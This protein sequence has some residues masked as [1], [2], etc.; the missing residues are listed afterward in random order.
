V[1][2]KEINRHEMPGQWKKKNDKMTR[3][4]TIWH[5]GGQNDTKMDKMAGMEG[6]ARRLQ[7]SG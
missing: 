4:W 3:K 5:R 6:L 7:Y 1:K 2:K